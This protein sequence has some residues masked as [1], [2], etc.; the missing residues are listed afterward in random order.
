VAPDMRQADEPRMTSVSAAGTTAGWYPDPWQAGALR[1]WD[2]GRWTPAT[3][4]GPPW[5]PGSGPGPAIRADQERLSREFDQ[6]Q[7]HRA[8]LLQ[9]LQQI[10]RHLADVDHELRALEARR[11]AALTAPVPAPA[12]LLAPPAPPPAGPG[13]APAGGR[14]P[15]WRAATVGN[16]LLGVG[17]VLLTI[18]ALVFATVAWPS[19]DDPQRALV[20]AGVTAICAGATVA[21]HKR[22]P[23]T[24]QAFSVLFVGFLLVDWLA[25]RR[26]GVGTG[27]TLAWW[28]A[29]GF[30][31]AAAVAAFV[32]RAL[33]MVVQQVVGVAA[34]AAAAS[35]A[36]AAVAVETHHPWFVATMGLALA[37]VLSVVIA[38]GMRARPPWRTA[39]VTTS[40]GSCAFA[41]ATLGTAVMTVGVEGSGALA[42]LA[43]AAVAAAPVAVRVLARTPSETA[44]PYDVLGATAALALGAGATAALAAA[45]PGSPTITVLAA[46][47]LS[48]IAV[49]TFG[50]SATRVGA[51]VAGVTAIAVALTI[52]VAPTLVLLAG[53]VAVFSLAWHG[54]ADA[55]VLSVL[56][57]ALGTEVDSMLGGLWLAGVWSCAALA[58]A[59]AL[60]RG[61]H[62]RPP[63]QPSTWFACSAMAAAIAAVAT[64]VGSSGSV[65]AVV[66]VSLA[67]ASACVVVAVRF[68]GA[69]SRLLIDPLAPMVLALAGALT[70]LAWSVFD[71]WCNVAA[72]TVVVLVAAAAGGSSS[73]RDLRS[74]LWSTASVSALVLAAVAPAAAGAAPAIVGLCLTALSA[75]TLLAA[76]ALLPRARCDRTT[77]LVAAVIGLVTGISFG[78][79]GW[80]DG[81]HWATALAVG[82]AGLALV[83]V[84]P[85]ATDALL[86]GTALAT[87][88]ALLIAA[89]ALATAALGGTASVAGVVASATASLL[90][91]VAVAV[92]HVQPRRLD[93]TARA[94]VAAT[95]VIGCAIGAALAAIGTGNPLTQG[96]DTDP[97]LLVVSLAVALAAVA[98]A[99]WRAPDDDVHLALLAVAVAT[100]VAEGGLLPAAI[101]VRAPWA[102]MVA[103]I[104]A[105]TLLAGGT[106]LLRRRDD[107]R[108]AQVVTGAALP[109]TVALAFAGWGTSDRWA[110][111]VAVA[112]SSAACLVAA[113]RT[114]ERPWRLTLLVAGALA[115][116]VSVGTAATAAGADGPLTGVTL[117]AA[118]AVGIVLAT[119]VLG[120]RPGPAAG[121]ARTVVEQT[122]LATIMIGVVVA[123]GDPVRLAEALTV[124][125]PALAVA[126]LRP[127]RP[128]YQPMSVGVAVLAVWAWIWVA[129]VREPEAY[130]LPAAAGALVASILVLR[131][132]PAVSS[133]LAYGPA[134][135]LALV[136]SLVLCVSE[137]GAV[138][139]LALFVGGVAI[140]LLGAW[141]RLQA[142]VIAGALTVVV[143]ALDT[144]WPVAVQI[145]RWILLAAAGAGFVWLGAT[146][147]RRRRQA[148][149]VGSL[150]GHL[151]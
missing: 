53:P 92:Q 62:R 88:T 89:S 83:L 104:T 58:A 147:E 17:T 102:A 98:V 125:F 134:L 69:D 127:D 126:G 40:I 10:D 135:F 94:A 106:L 3:S 150:I 129:G 117:A 133:W 47:G 111:V 68:T 96:W 119:W 109:L 35:C 140:L 139:P 130:T 73:R 77:P 44:V 38:R 7:R 61:S 8:E 28:W 108:T 64:V 15:E 149:H 115:A 105:A 22:L 48:M 72:L 13:P 39:A 112:V 91:L 43:L 19:L 97:W 71:R 103:T 122:A 32:A 82:I 31:L 50:P 113:A 25:I 101:G 81:H 145:P 138:R 118:G 60:A 74:A 46:V 6:A 110:P 34:A 54:P 95:G 29:A 76:A 12:P 33:R 114:P 146:I 121:D 86:R 100:A 136:P 124:A 99:S 85:Q 93:H 63:A 23:T 59:L 27:W 52:A 49:A 26:A 79:A 51:S 148:R 87:G 5:P 21:L 131:E 80:P 120:G 143:V 142:P 116:P 57:Q 132:R 128:R 45:F 11:A 144:L 151:H 75:G 84:T 65:A 56:S 66:A 123:A 4:G 14:A 9:Q 141:K 20:L 78:A 18:A 41:A 42:G 24:A 70:G 2:G 137:Q 30:A 16:V 36:V 90:L 107:A 55:S 1:W 67:V 37:A